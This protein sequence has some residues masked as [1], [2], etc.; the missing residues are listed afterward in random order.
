MKF[1]LSLILMA[2]LSYAASLYLPWWSIAIVAFLVSV[3]IPLKPAKAFICG[4]LSLFLLWGGMSYIISSNN[5]NI[6]AQKIS[7]LMIFMNSPFLLIIL[8]GLIAGLVAGFAS[9]SGSYLRYRKEDNYH[10]KLA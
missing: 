2:L 4:F 6:L 3:I 10:N 5:G 8:T 7:Q 9:L 1:I